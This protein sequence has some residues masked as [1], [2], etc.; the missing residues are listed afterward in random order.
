MEHPALDEFA[1]RVRGLAG[2]SHL[3]AAAVEVL[4]EFEAAGVQSILL[5]G[6]VLARRLYT[7]AEHRSYSDVDV[8]VAPHELA[9]AREVLRGLGYIDASAQHGIEDVA[10]V[11]HAENWAQAHQRIGPLMIDLHWKLAGVQAPPDI[12]WKALAAR[13]ERI[14]LAGRPTV[15]LDPRG[16]ALH[17]ATHA[18][19][20]GPDDLKAI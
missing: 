6:P 1:R 8:I 7:E 16:L 5:K 4:D 13:T 3:D 18:A 19:Q 20:H 10:G 9:A 12:A 17:L 14:D 15:A 2:R 11:V